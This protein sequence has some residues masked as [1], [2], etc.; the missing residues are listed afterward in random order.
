MNGA[1]GSPENSG[2]ICHPKDNP[3]AQSKEERAPSVQEKS[4]SPEKQAFPPESPK[5][6]ATTQGGLLI[7]DGQTLQ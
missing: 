4:T 5:K 6:A 2:K 3:I 1:K 7:N